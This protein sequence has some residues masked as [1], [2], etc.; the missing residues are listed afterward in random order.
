M[1]LFLFGKRNRSEREEENKLPVDPEP[2]EKSADIFLTSLL[3]GGIEAK[4]Q[5]DS[6]NDRFIYWWVK[7]D[8]LEVNCMA[9]R[10]Q[11]GTTARRGSVS[12][13]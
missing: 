3:G 11:K 7:L 2:Q 9:K 4:K 6:R 1:C 8:M 12:P 5:N 10:R 13:W